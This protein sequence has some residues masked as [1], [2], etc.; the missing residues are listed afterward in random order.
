MSICPF[1]K[2]K[3]IEHDC[4]LYTQ[5]QGTNPNSGQPIDE[6]GCAVAWLPILLIEGAKETRQGA[7]AIESFRNEVVKQQDD[8]NKLT[9]AKVQ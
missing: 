4:Q 2:K 1:L 5:L 9:F 8:L 6:W 3:C 7:A